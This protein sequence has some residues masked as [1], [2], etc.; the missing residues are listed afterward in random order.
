MASDKVVKL[1]EEV[2]ALT[3][4]NSPDLLRL[5][6]KNSAYHSSSRSCAAALQQQAQ[7]R[8]RS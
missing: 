6:K 8:S 2:K 4:W 5:L 7:Q 1:I 3:Y